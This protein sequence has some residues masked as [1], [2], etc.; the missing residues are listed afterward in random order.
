[1]H[2]CTKNDKREVPL[3]TINALFATL[4]VGNKQDRCNVVLGTWTRETMIS[5][6]RYMHVV[7]GK[8]KDFRVKGLF[9]P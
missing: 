9:V 6:G 1:M 7:E 5:F 8:E 2:Y 4:L 3:P